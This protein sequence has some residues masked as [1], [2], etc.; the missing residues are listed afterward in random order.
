M[1]TA[2]QYEG[3]APNRDNERTYAPIV[4]GVM[5]FSTYTGA[6]AFVS[7]AAVTVDWTLSHDF[8][9]ELTEN[10]VVT[11][12]D[13]L[14]AGVWRL[15]VYQENDG[16]TYTLSWDWN[17]VK[18]EGGTPPVIGDG[19]QVL[20]LYCD[21]TFWYVRTIMSDTTGYDRLVSI[22][23]AP[24]TVDN[25]LHVPNGGTL[26]IVA[27]GTYADAHTADVT[28]LVD[29]WVSATPANVS[30]DAAG[31]LTF[32]DV[33]DSLITASIGTIDGTATAHGD[34]P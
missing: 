23:L 20:E 27:T 9:I 33:G 1:A 4:N 24:L 15:F 30:V 7:G 13:P 26:Q 17:T 5:V 25:K 12:P 19:G 18:F 6:G 31:L 34:A 11:L 29:S 21:G 22:A 8:M 3:L 28:A 10:T 14:A 32:A 16:D 2:T